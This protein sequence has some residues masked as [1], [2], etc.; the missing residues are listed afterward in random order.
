M[1]SHGANT[2]AYLPV[3]QVLERKKVYDINKWT[4]WL[5]LETPETFSS[6]SFS[7]LKLVFGFIFGD[8]ES[9]PFPGMRTALIFNLTYVQPILLLQNAPTDSS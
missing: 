4:K 3:A 6:M 5:L 7:T 8:I 2:L 1:G 9:T